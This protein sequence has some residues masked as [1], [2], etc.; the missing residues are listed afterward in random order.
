VC[1]LCVNVCCDHVAKFI[2]SCKDVDDDDDDELIAVLCVCIVL[3]RPGASPK[4]LHLLRACVCVCVCVCECVC[5][6]HDVVNP[7]RVC[8][9][10]I[11]AWSNICVLC[12]SHASLS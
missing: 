10:Y 6:V 3:I 2:S 5:A 7:G 8:V 9:A 12:A 4:N 1:G 11:H